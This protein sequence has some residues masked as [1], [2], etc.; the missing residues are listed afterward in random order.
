MQIL[1]PITTAVGVAVALGMAPV[2]LSQAQDTASSDRPAN[3]PWGIRAPVSRT[4]DATAD[5]A[6]VREAIAG[7]LLEIRLGELAKDRAE[8][9]A[10]ED[11]AEKMVE[12]HGSMQRKWVVLAR[13]SRLPAESE[14]GPAEEATVRRLESLSGGEFDRAYMT[15][16]VQNH[17][18]D[19][20]MLQRAQQSAQSSQVRQLAANGLPTVQEHL[21]TARELGRR[22]GV[23]TVA[24]LPP[25]RTPTRFDTLR[26]TA[27]DRTK[28]R[29]DR[30][31]R[32]NLS[33][34]DGYFVR[35]VLQDHV[36][37]IRM[38]ERARREARTERMRDFAEELA[39]EFEKWQE[40]WETVASR[41]GVE[42]KGN[43]GRLHRQKV[44]ALEKADDNDFDR[45]YAAIVIENLE[46]IVPYFQKE[47]KAVRS[48]A[49]RRLVEDEL[50]VIRDYLARARRLQQ[51]ESARADASKD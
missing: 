11:F 35:E 33:S 27:E 32:A 8:D 31:A 10:V 14:L 37:E 2:S 17:E 19:V 36:M 9:S 24:A 38:A 50:P 6:L 30:D 44:D 45:V 48:A 23:S 41:N 18:R 3:N 15:N 5:S 4:A 20:A 39:K 12:D 28:P 21:A 46:S 40:R 43:I 1:K 25:S 16:M 49:V 7:N 47:G 34:E 42:W 13:T 51:Q 26:T 22:I 29:R